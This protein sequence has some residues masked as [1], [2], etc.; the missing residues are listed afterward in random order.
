MFIVILYS[1]SSCICYN[2]CDTNISGTVPI[3]GAAPAA[4]V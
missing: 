3:A 2:L 1:I 4:V